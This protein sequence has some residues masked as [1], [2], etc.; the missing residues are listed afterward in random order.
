VPAGKGSHAPFATLAAPA[1]LHIIESLKE[2]Y[3][4][5]VII[6]PSFNEYA[7]GLLLAART[8]STILVTHG[9][10]TQKDLQEAVSSLRGK[11]IHIT[12]TIYHRGAYPNMR[13]LK[14]PAAKL[15]PGDKSQ[16]LAKANNQ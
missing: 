2:K 1:L 10:S 12:G 13:S 9:G 15:P 8:D 14:M 6:A 4:L 7:E 16:V 11:H 5:L 3:A